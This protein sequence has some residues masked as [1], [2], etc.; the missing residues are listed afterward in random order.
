[1]YRLA[2]I[3]ISF[4]AGDTGFANTGTHYVEESGRLLVSSSYRWDRLLDPVQPPWLV[5]RVD[6]LPSS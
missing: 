4:R 6:E 1:M 3:D 5:C 2:S